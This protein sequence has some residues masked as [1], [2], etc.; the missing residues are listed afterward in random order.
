MEDDPRH[1]VPFSSHHAISDTVHTI[2]MIVTADVGLDT[3]AEAVF[4]RFLY[5]ACHHTGQ[6]C[7]FLS[8]LDSL[9]ES[10]HCIGTSL[11]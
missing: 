2:N 7:S 6:P 5:R 11:Q 1:N 9:E 10:R 4:V 8:I 3:P